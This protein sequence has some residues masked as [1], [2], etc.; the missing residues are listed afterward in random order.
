MNAKTA[1][2]EE[3]EIPYTASL[4]GNIRQILTGLQGFESMRLKLR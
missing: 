3:G 2:L 4:I 1:E